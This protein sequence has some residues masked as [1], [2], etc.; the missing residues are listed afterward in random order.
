MNVPQG[1]RVREVFIQ[2]GDE[3]G[4]EDGEMLAWEE[5]QQQLENAVEEAKRGLEDAGKRQEDS[6]R[7]GER[8]NLTK[9]QKKYVNP[10][11]RTVMRYME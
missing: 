3:I 11:D 6:H 8:E 4:S 9:E 7:Q 5:K 1:I 2:P 10:G